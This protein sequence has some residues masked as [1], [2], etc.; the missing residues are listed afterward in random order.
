MVVLSVIH[1]PDIPYLSGTTNILW[2]YLW[3]VQILLGIRK[4]NATIIRT[5]FPFQIKKSRQWR[6][7]SFTF[8]LLI[9]TY[10]SFSVLPSLALLRPGNMADF[11]SAHNNPDDNLRLGR[12]LWPSKF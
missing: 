9:S 10:N 12:M 4:E 2:I 6:D 1:Y 7:F 5:W 11:R 8:S 3:S